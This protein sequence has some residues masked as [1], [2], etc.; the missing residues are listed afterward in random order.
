[1][2]C[3]GKV[4]LVGAGLGNHETLTTQSLQLLQTADTVVT[5][6]LVPRQLL[7][8][9]SLECTV[10]PVGKRGGQASTPQAD[11]NR[12]L[13]QLSHSGQTVVR[14]KSG[15]PG[16]FGR[17]TEEVRALEA[18]NCPF[19]IVPGISS[20]IAGP[21]AA[22]IPLTD[23]HLSQCFVV[24]SVHQVETLPWHALAGIDT[25][26]LLMGTRSLRAICE[27]LVQA[28]K[29]PDEPIACIREAGRAS[30]QMW[31][32]TLATFAD[33]MESPD[34]RLSPAIIVVGQVVNA[35]VQ[36]DR[37]D[38]QPLAGKTVLVTRANAQ[39]GAL[40]QLLEAQG[41]IV[42]DMPTIAIV[43]PSSYRD[44]D[45]AIAQLAS[46]DWLILTS[47]NGVEAFFQRL[48]DRGLDSRALSATRIAVVGQK[49]AQ[50]IEQ[51]GIRPDFIPSEFVADAVAAELPLERSEMRVLFPR[52]ESG[53]RDVLVKELTQR[54]AQVVEVAAYQSNCPERVSPKAL[55]LLESGQVDAVTFASSKTVRHFCQLLRGAQ[56]E[57]SA[58][59]TVQFAAIGPKT[60]E[61]CTELLGRTDICAREYTL[62]GLVAA[63]VASMSAS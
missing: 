36:V 30:Q 1:M 57:F 20:A 16:V 61:T 63:I 59:D 5:D 50:A 22:G 62:A 35:R 15:D 11:I 18:A 4:W 6:D 53:G 46:F 13:V 48:R 47:A 21:L 41:A 33:A 12:L 54:G 25:L 23:K 55:S 43:P 28:G 3:Y 39:A 45:E 60:A 27:R 29:S 51:F 19:E 10:I 52:V 32:G 8:A 24:A 7:L 9:A 58:L 42:V 56:F 34:L 31:T 40:T 37:S 17:L 2:S 26:V 14:L 49:T 44:L 38:R